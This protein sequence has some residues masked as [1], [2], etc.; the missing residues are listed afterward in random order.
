MNNKSSPD[1]HESHSPLIGSGEVRRLFILS[2]GPLCSYSHFYPYSHSRSQ[3]CS[4]ELVEKER[5]SAPEK[6]AKPAQRDIRLHVANR[7]SVVVDYP[8]GL[9]I[10][11]LHAFNRSNIR[12]SP[13]GPLEKR[14]SNE[15]HTDLHHKRLRPSFC[16]REEDHVPGIKAII[17]I[18][19]G[20]LAHDR[21]C[22][23]RIR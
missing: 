7:T 19:V 15:R 22:V 3:P 11:L 18:S 16:N 12:I 8:L 21:A 5:L 1:P 4:R 23:P 20:I 13:Y 2:K 6:T 9:Q 10:Y 14:S 17:D